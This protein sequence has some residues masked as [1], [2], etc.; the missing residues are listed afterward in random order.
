MVLD[1]RGPI[2]MNCLQNLYEETARRK[3]AGY[4]CLELRKGNQDRV[5]D[6][7]VV[8]IKTVTEV[9]YVRGGE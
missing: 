3:S 6:L 2:W 7:E 8:S 1:I 4:M 5:I 9:M